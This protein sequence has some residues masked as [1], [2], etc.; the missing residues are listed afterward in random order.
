MPYDGSASL[1]L[2]LD[3]YSASVVHAVE[4]VAPTVLH[5]AVRRRDGKP[6]GHGSGE[7]G[8]AHV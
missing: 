5:V 8:R 2:D 6:G 3:P 7:I 4:R 1:D